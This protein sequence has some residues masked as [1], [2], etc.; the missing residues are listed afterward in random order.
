MNIA[1]IMAGGLG[2]TLLQDIPKQFLNVYDKPIIIY[3]LEV[4]Q[5][6]AEIDGIVIS[7][8]DGWEEMCKAYARQFGI[9]KLMDVVTGGPDGQT[10]AVNGLLVMHKWCKED[11]I[12]V[13]HDAIRPMVTEDIISDCIRVC[14]EYRCGVAAVRCQEPVVRSMD[15][16]KGIESFERFEMMKIQTPQAYPYGQLLNLYKEAEEKGIRGV[17]HANTILTRLGKQIYFSKGSDKNLKILSLD[18]LDIFKALY[19]TEREDWIKYKN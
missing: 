5:K 19:A 1:L 11:D 8:L 12:V 18:D 17:I 15:G 16:L 3:A 9:T 13:I 2:Q 14:R 10:S 6:H 7:C 4:F